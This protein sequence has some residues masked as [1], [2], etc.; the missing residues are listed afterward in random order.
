VFRVPQSF[1]YQDLPGSYSVSNA[2]LIPSGDSIVY[3]GNPVIPDLPTGTGLVN[4]FVNDTSYLTTVPTLGYSIP[5]TYTGPIRLG[6][7]STYAKNSTANATIASQGE[8][9]GN[10]KKEPE[11]PASAQTK[12]EARNME[13]VPAVSPGRLKVGEVKKDHGGE[14]AIQARAKQGTNFRAVEVG[15]MPLRMSGEFQPFELSEVTI[16]SEKVSK[17]R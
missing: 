7:K 6:F 17:D 11:A 3:S 16:Q 13:Q 9:G 4:G 2:N 1:V 15:V 10:Q 14:K 12:E 8:S 5:S